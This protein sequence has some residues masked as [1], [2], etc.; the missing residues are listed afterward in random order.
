[1]D[2]GKVI[3]KLISQLLEQRPMLI[4]DSPENFNIRVFKKITHFDESSRVFGQVV[5]RLDSIAIMVDRVER[6]QRDPND[7]SSQDVVGFLPVLITKYPTKVR[8]VLMSAESPPDNLLPD[9]PISIC[10]IST[11]RSAAHNSFDTQ[12]RGRAK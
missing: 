7:T 10:M 11:K 4:G 1:L 9:L 12:H 5:S 2:S 8:I 6:C 3:K